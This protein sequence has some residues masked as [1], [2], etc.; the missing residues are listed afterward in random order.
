[1]RKIMS[2]LSNFQRFGVR[3]L[4]IALMLSMGATMLN[5]VMVG[6]A[7]NIAP[8]ARVSFTFDDGLTSALTQAAPVLQKYG[9]AG[10]N[11]VTTGCIGTNGT[12]AA[13]EGASYMNWDQVRQLQNTYGWEIGSHTANHPLMSELSA[14]AQEQE[15]VTSK[16]T[17][18]AQGIDAKN[19]ATPYGDYN[20]T[21]LA[22][23]AKYYE[24]HRGFWDIDKNTWP[25]N[26]YTI[27]VM[28]VQYPVTVASVKTA[29]DQAA[30]NK[31][32]LV[33]VFHD[34][35]PSASTD[36][37]DY[38]YS[39]SNLDNIAAY[40]KARQDAGAIK[41]IRVDEGLV[42]SDV[43]LLPNGNFASGISGGWSTNNASVF[44]ADNGNNGSHPNPLNSVKMTAGT[45]NSHLFSPLVSVDPS[46]TYMLKNFLN[47]TA[48]SGG[49]VAFY[50]DEYDANGNWISGQYKGGI[51]ALFAGNYNFTYKAT[52]AAVSK[53]SLQVIMVGNSGIAGYFDNAQWFAL[54]A[55]TPTPPPVTPTNL[56]ANGTFDA[57]VS[58]GWTTNTPATIFDDAANHG[59]PA[60]PVH[61]VSVQATS[62]NTHLFSPLVN[63][64]STKAY[65]LTVFTNILTLN[66]G[67]VG[68]Y[69][70]EYDANGNWISG[71]YKGGA[72]ATGAGDTNFAYTPS[73]ASVSKASLQIIVVGNSG[74]TA[75]VDHIRWF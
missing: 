29:V 70:D 71:Q 21:T 47:V 74:I 1:M 42:K 11:Y 68:F 36:P 33:L 16:Q 4:A 59:A 27:K 32:W 19:F 64:V 66:S 57:G 65:D 35:Q 55:T 45:A 25:Y 9:M 23:A 48:I 60:N 69:I 72:R 15:L 24:S 5:P 75:Y 22:T 56:V 13:D 3:F 67:E 28:Q 34:V 17:L 31:Q 73:S 6:A 61:A 10:T 18:A 14:Q 20:Q 39:T 40:V 43:N 26:D 49:E 7:T 62:T 38:E 41:A 8:A 30:A 37:D 44:A 12:C 51:S 53:S 58:G 63:V 2:L 46:A 54:T 50:I 52:S